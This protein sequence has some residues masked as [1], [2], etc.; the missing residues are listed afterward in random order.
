MA[1]ALPVLA[2]AAAVMWLLTLVAVWRSASA[3]SLPPGVPWWCRPLVCWLHLAQPVVRAWHRYAYCLSRRGRLLGAAA[4][5]RDGTPRAKR[6]SASVHDLYYTSRDGVGREALLEELLRRAGRDGWSGDFVAAHSRH[7]V[8]LNG[9][10]WHDVRVVTAT[11]EL[12]GNRRFTRVRLELRWAGLPRTLSLI[13]AAWTAVAVTSL[14]PWAGGVAAGAWAIVGTGSAV[15]RRR[16]RS[17]VS[18]L[19]HR[20]ARRVGLTPFPDRETPAEAADANSGVATD[21]SMSSAGPG[22]E[23]CAD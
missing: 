10:R 11:E 6:I 17:G 3:A 9:D 14:S 7:D 8:E 4:T 19:L 2:W 16:C 15:S 22:P 1:V 5:G 12:G 13:A 18:A 21:D 23:L 20:A